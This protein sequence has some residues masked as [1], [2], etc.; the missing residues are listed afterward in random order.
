MPFFNS[1]SLSSQTQQTH[2]WHPQGSHFESYRM[3][4]NLTR[5]RHIANK[6]HA[7]RCSSQIQAVPPDIE[8]EESNARDQFSVF[9]MAFVM[10]SR[11]EIG[12]IWELK[13]VPFF[14]QACFFILYKK[15]TY[16]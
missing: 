1:L 14:F 15:R 9:L 3:Y 7:V 8:V 2:R 11:N 12:N 13:V 6:M 5:L 4:T 10:E 16:L